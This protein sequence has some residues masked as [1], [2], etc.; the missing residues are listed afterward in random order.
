M[1]EIL[2][3]LRRDAEHQLEGPKAPRWAKPVGWAIAVAIIA[4]VLWA[5][6]EANP[7]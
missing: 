6:F 4:V 7:L 1:P 2:G 3:R 5:L